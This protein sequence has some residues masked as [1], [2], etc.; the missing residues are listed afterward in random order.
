MKRKIRNSFYRRYGIHILRPESLVPIIYE[1]LEEVRGTRIKELPPCIK[2]ID[3]CVK[4]GIEAPSE[5]ELVLF[6]NFLRRCFNYSP[7]DV[8]E[9]LKTMRGYDRELTEASLRKYPPLIWFCGEVKRSI[10]HI[11][12]YSSKPSFCEDSFPLPEDGREDIIRV[13]L[14]K[15]RSSPFYCFIRRA[16]KISSG[17]SPAAIRR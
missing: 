11:C 15:S 8:Q 4:K 9:A 12:P 6:A 1:R 17:S 3:D 13:G 5:S 7:E 2:A 14:A 16:S 10:P